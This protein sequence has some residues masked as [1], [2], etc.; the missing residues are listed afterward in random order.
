[1]SK[2]IVRLP[3]WILFLALLGL[4]LVLTACGA[5]ASVAAP[6]G[7][8][9]EP[10]AGQPGIGQPAGGAVGGNGS[11][12]GTGSSGGTGS[13][14][15][16]QGPAASAGTDG[17]SAVNDINIDNLLVIKT[18]TLNVQVANLD[19]ALA[20]ASQ[21][22]STLGGYLAGSS[23][24]GSDDRAVASVTYRIPA[25]RW[26]DALVGIRDLAEKV[27]DEQSQS[28]D[29]TGQVVDLGARI[30]NLEATEAAMQA[31]M[32]KAT[33]ISEILE[34]QGQLTEIRGQIEQATAER[35]H[36]QEQAAYSTLTVNFSLK[37]AQ[38]VVETQK[39]YDPAREVD[40]ASASLVGMLQGVATAGI[41]FGI[42]WL[43]VL[44]ALG[45]VTAVV[46]LALRRLAPAGTGHEGGRPG[47][48]GGP[49]GEAPLPP[50]AAA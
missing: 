4:T 46:I 27:L 40:E 10:G 32:Q 35:K 41:W 38:A 8:G 44:A 37:P 5:A 23:R 43:P 16:E 3:R 20:K 30:T 22:M 25:A 13:G 15:S 21:K 9:G 42:V 24:R 18:G 50:P 39:G 29:V 14:G 49:G 48:P 6:Q 33:K 36:L 11:G 47:G 34:V 28:Q 1:M 26:D 31:I 2:P 7:P 17:G 19:D 12:G 45:L